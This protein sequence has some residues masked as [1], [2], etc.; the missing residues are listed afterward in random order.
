M[1]II[2]KLKLKKKILVDIILLNGYLLLVV[3]CQ[4]LDTCQT[5]PLSSPYKHTYNSPRRAP[6]Q[7]LEALRLHVVLQII[8]N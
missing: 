6:T 5:A 7:E 8:R 2:C 1:K 3:A 4:H